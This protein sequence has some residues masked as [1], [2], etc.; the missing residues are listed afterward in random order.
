[1]KKLFVFTAIII[2]STILGCSK[3]TVTSPNENLSSTG[4]LT[5]Q[6]DKVN[7]PQNVVTVAAYLTRPDYDTLSSSMNIRT[8]SSA[9]LY[10]HL[11]KQ[12]QIRLQPHSY[13][14]F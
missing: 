8:D 4:K 13:I 3:N 6:I 10:H 11:N 2:L 1:M 5:L 9:N 7:A 14:P 12:S